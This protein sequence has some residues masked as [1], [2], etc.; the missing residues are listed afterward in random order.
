MLGEFFLSV[1]CKEKLDELEIC[2]PAIF[3]AAMCGLEWLK[4]QVGW[5]GCVGVCV[6]GVT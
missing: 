4:D 1:V 2:Q 6:C 3:V 5:V